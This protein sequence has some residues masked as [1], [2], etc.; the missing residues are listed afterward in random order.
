MKDYLGQELSVEDEVIFI[1]PNYREFQK[2]KIIRFTPQ[3]VI[4]EY[5][6]TWNYGPSGHLIEMKQECHQLIKIQP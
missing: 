6:N 2:A 1:P 3:F 5:N 4:I